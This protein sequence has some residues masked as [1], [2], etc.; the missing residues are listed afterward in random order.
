MS[1]PDGRLHVLVY[2]VVLLVVFCVFVKVLLVCLT[3]D[4]VFGL[5]VN[6][7]LSG[8]NTNSGRYQV[9]QFGKRAEFKKV[10]SWY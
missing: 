4:R 5:F 6:C 7:L 3:C 2:F 1:G 10:T 8:A 9:R